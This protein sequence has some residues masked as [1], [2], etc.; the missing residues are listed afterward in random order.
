MWCAV[1]GDR[2]NERKFIE[3]EGVDAIL[4]IMET[5]PVVLRAQTLGLLS[6]L[7]A[8]EK[9]HPQIFIWKSDVSFDS[10][11]YFALLDFSSHKNNYNFE[12]V[13]FFLF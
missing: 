6:D 1:V 7:A 2:K 13:I 5:I 9:V 3:V 8:N 12:N 10:F 11:S 4:D